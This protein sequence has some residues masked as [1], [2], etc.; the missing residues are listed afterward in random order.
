M[1]HGEVQVAHRSSRFVGAAQRICTGVR[2]LKSV[3]QDPSAQLSGNLCVSLGAQ[4]VA[5]LL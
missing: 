2:L 5:Q 3:M 4:A 1:L